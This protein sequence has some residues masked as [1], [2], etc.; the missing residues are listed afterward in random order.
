MS[1]VFDLQVQ[2]LPEHLDELGQ[3]QQMA[4]LAWMQQIAQA[5]STDLGLSL[6]IFQ[7]LKH[8]MVVVEQHVQYRKAAFLADQLILRTWVSKTDSMHSYRD[9]ALY[10]ARDAAI[11]LVGTTKWA[12][13]EL[14]TARPKRMSPTFIQAY[15]AL[16]GEINP[17]DFTENI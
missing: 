17:F 15:A 10:R 2:I 9:Y 3:V 13:V 6:E 5:H 14:S 12:C 11:I 1:Q 4:Y 7:Q 16:S 8:A